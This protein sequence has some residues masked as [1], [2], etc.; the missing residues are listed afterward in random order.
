[1][2][3]PFGFT[4]TFTK[5]TSW[6]LINT[7]CEWCICRVMPRAIRKLATVS[8]MSS[9]VICGVVLACSQQRLLKVTWLSLTFYFQSYTC[10]AAD[11]PAVGPLLEQKQH[12]ITNIT[13]LW[14]TRLILAPFLLN[15]CFLSLS[16][17]HQRLQVCWGQSRN[18]IPAMA[19]DRSNTAV[20][21]GDAGMHQHKQGI[22]VYT[23]ACVCVCGQQCRAVCVFISAACA[24]LQCPESVKLSPQAHFWPTSVTQ[25]KPRSGYANTQTH[26]LLNDW[27]Q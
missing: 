27:E 13:K 15:A 6:N 7:K 4:L 19:T 5:C 24:P 18:W 26:T 20:V 11:L 8:C 14:Y 21:Q 3:N 1:M 23:R 16:W 2:Y 22:Y 12:M 9:N 10:T 25:S 17:L